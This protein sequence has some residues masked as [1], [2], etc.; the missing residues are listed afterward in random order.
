MTGNGYLT[1]DKIHELIRCK[2]GF[3]SKPREM[4]KV[5][6]NMSQRFSVV[7]V[8]T[9]NEFQV[10]INYSLRMPQDFSIGLMY[11]DFLLFRVNGFHGTTRKGFYLASH[12]AVPHTH[13]LTAEDIANGRKAHPSKIEE[14]PGEYIDLVTA[15]LYFFHYCGIIGFEDFFSDSEQMSMFD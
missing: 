9:G 10:F 5:N 3:N 12:H 13:T 2:K 8:D 15:R 11:G 6:Q 1:D 4:A 14:V 7:S